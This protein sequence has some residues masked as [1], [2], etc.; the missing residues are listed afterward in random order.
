MK[1][2]YDLGNNVVKKRFVSYREAVEL[3][4]QLTGG[5]GRPCKYKS[6]EVKDYPLFNSVEEVDTDDRADI[7]YTRDDDGKIVGYNYH[8][9]RKNKPALIG[10]L[11]RDD[12]NDILRMYSYY[13]DSSQQRIISRHFPEL[14]LIDLKR[15]L[16]AFAFSSPLI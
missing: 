6:E 2:K 10:T 5:K 12:M 7:S 14:S 8:I 1:Q 16:R 15:I 4:E 11:S 9:Y 3:Y 13:G